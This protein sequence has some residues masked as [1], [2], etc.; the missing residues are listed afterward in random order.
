MDIR[1]TRTSISERG[2]TR[3]V[4]SMGARCKHALGGMRR[5]RAG[6]G[7][8][9]RFFLPPLSPPKCENPN[10]RQNPLSTMSSQATTGKEKKAAASAAKK[11]K[12]RAEK[13]GNEE[14]R[15]KKKAAAAAEAE[16]SGE[17]HAAGDVPPAGDDEVSGR[18]PVATWVC[19]NLGVRTA[20]PRPQLSLS[21]GSSSRRRNRRRR[22]RS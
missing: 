19:A 7:A 16:A 15:G 10:T 1:T 6:C 3:S 5:Y 17:S 9:R 12:V 22:L 20:R 4:R 2:T 14:T 21:T 13:T 11:A 18:L 8:Q